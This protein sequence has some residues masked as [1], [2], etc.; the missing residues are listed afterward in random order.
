MIKKLLFAIII[1]LFSGSL[2]SQNLI[3]TEIVDGTAS[4]GYPKYV[5]VTNIGTSTADLNGYI[6]K[7]SANGGGFSDAYTFT[8]TY[9]LPAG[10]SVVVT[11]IDSVNQVWGDYNLPT[12]TYAIYGA[13]NVNGNGDDCYALANPS[14]TVI[15][16]Y[17]E[18]LVDGTGKRGRK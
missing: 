12:P 7:K 11:N 9:N 15:D 16:I 14:N 6:I 1:A 5:E 4:G 8:T 18:E 17:G 10:E 3:I 13:T 2:F